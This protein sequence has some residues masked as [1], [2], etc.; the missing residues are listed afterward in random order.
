MSTILGN[1]AWVVNHLAHLIEKSKINCKSKTP[2]QIC[3]PYAK[4]FELCNFIA[5]VAL[6]FQ[7][8]GLAVGNVNVCLEGACIAALMVPSR[9]MIFQASIREVSISSCEV[10]DM[11]F[12][13][14][15]LLHQICNYQYF[16]IALC[17]N[18]S[19]EMPLT[20]LN[21]LSGIHFPMKGLGKPVTRSMERLFLRT[22]ASIC[23]T[24]PSLGSGKST[25]RSIR[26]E[27]FP[28][29]PSRIPRGKNPKT[30]FLP[31]ELGLL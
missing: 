23:R 15:L 19:T 6:N 22:H 28:I 30:T 18:P 1:Y 7:S 31:L 25:G 17:A 16:F 21:P 24:L 3:R 13:F 20:C 8:F 2:P 27:L 26:L 11:N 14:S 4:P 9:T 10:S 12:P 29:L 5:N